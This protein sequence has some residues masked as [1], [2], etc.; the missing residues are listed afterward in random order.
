VVWRARGARPQLSGQLLVVSAD[1]DELHVV[2]PLGDARH[3]ARAMT[4]EQHQ[5][6]RSGG[7]KPHPDPRGG[8]VEH[9]RPVEIGAQDHAA[10]G[11]HAVRCMPERHRLR[12]GAG[13]A[14]N[15]ML[16]LVGFDP[17]MGRV[18]GQIGEHGHEGHVGHSASRL[19]NSARLKLGMSDT[20]R[21]GRARPQC[22]RKP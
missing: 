13:R 10:G 19:S 1:E 11:V 2:Q 18:V 4:A 14:A 8:S 21:S 5:A 22:A 3:G 7:V 6:G 9:R 15:E 16:R 20:T 17:E 12:Q